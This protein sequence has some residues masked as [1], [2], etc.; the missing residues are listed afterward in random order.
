[1]T[2]TILITGASSGIG[3]CCALG[4]KVRG[5]RVFAITRSLEAAETLKTQGLESI[6][7]DLDN[8]LSIKNAVSQVLEQTGGTLDYLFNNAGYGQPGAVE[9]LSRDAIR[10]QFESNLFGPLELTN[11]IIPVMRQQGH[12]R[13]IFT[14]SILGM[15][16]LAYRGAYNASKFALEGLVDTLRQELYDTNIK[17]SLIEPG[18]IISKFREHAQENFQQN[19]NIEQSIHQEKY[20]KAM[21]RQVT[22]KILDPFT[23]PPE[24][25]LQRLIHALE[26]PRAQLRY[27]VT[28]PAYFLSTL[29]RLLPGRVLDWILQRI[30]ASETQ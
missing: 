8:S 23:R 4:L 26:N 22:K 2:K 25:V 28:P 19:I 30:S 24:A 13:I 1:M 10:Q 17:I 9:D 5:Y 27:Y 15:V 14:S 16:A 11:L 18:P 21:Q 29:K 12:G 6:I 7:L 3:L 20:E